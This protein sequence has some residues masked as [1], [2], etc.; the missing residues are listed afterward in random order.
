MYDAAQ[1]LSTPQIVQV[2]A[3]E[4]G[5]KYD[6]A[7]SIIDGLSFALTIATI[8]FFQPGQTFPARADADS[9]KLTVNHADGPR[10]PR[11]WLIRQSKFRA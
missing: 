8:C 9:G 5:A 6:L 7:A 4:A 1:E 11:Q 3:P 10:L 2:F